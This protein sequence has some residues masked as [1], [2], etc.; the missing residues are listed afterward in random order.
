MT[1]Q[2]PQNLTVQKSDGDLTFALLTEQ[3]YE[4]EICVFVRARTASTAQLSGDL[5]LAT[6]D[7]TRSMYI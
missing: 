3:E 1:I 5:Q 2:F 6:G 4:G 7:L